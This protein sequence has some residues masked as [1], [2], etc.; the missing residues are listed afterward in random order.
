ME[1]R[2]RGVRDKQSG[3]GIDFPFLILDF[4]FVIARCKVDLKCQMKNGK[5]K[6][7]SEAF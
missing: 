1:R 6:M 3:A 2:N 4:S 7:I 5:W